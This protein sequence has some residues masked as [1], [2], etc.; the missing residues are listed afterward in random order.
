[1]P[2]HKE[3]CGREALPV[4]LSSHWKGRRYCPVVRVQKK[5][6]ADKKKPNFKTLDN[7]RATADNRDVQ[8]AYLT[9]ENLAVKVMVLADTGSAYSA[10]PGSAVEDARKRG[11]PLK[12]EVLL[13]PIMLNMAIRGESDKQTCSATEMLM[14]AVTITT[15]PGPLCMRVFQ[16]IIVEEDMDHPLIGRPVIDEMGF[17]A[18]RHLDSV[19]DNIHLHDFSHIGEELLDMGKQHLGA[20]SKLLLMPADI[21]EFIEDLL[22]VLTLAKNMNLNRRE[23]A[24]P[25]ALAEDQCELQRSEDDDGDHGVLQPNVKFASFKEQALFYGDIPDDDPIDY[26]DVDVGKGIPEELADAIEGLLTSAEKGG[27]FLDGAQSLRQLVTECK[28]VFRLKLGADP[29]TNVKPLVIKIRDGTEPV[30]MS[31]RK[32][33]P[34]QLKFTRD[35]I[36]EIKEL[37]LVYKNSGAEWA[38][39]PLILPKPGL[40]HYRMTVDLRVPNASTKPTA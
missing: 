29:P 11:F 38:S 39:P 26:H 13:E 8:T 3:V 14:L 33:A 15:P 9:A 28:D 40:D 36:R 1:L 5:R 12:V 19:R 10:I 23:Q 20:L 32:Y 22:D 4:R 18:I 31:A 21:T 7:N 17:V 35:K 25:R 30:R 2:Q 27:M 6:D 37:G 24:K 34:P 16:Q